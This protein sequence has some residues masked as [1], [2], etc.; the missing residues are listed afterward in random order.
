MRVGGAFVVSVGHGYGKWAF[1]TGGPFPLVGLFHWWAFSTGGPFP[2]V[3]L[4]HW[5]AFS[6][7][8][9]LGCHLVGQ[10]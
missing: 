4:F 5:W 10:S 9:V 2:L 6:T 3:G 7:G 8:G 1:S